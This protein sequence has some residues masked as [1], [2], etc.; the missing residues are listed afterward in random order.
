MLGDDPAFIPE[1]EFLELPFSNLEHME[2]EISQ[3]TTQMSILSPDSRRL[4]LSQG[5][6]MIG[7]NLLPSSSAV[8][9]Y[10]LPGNDLFTTGDSA[11]NLGNYGGIFDDEGLLDD[12]DFEVQHDGQLVEIDA[13]ERERRKGIIVAKQE[14]LGSDSATSGQHLYIHGGG[15]AGSQDQVLIDADGDFVMVMDDDLNILPDAE[16]FPAM[17]DA[18]ALQNQLEIDPDF[19]EHPSSDSAAAPMKVRR[20]RSKK[21][22][23]ADEKISLPNSVLNGWQREYLPN[24]DAAIEAKTN[25][26]GSS[27]AKKNAYILTVGNGIGNAGQ[28]MGSTALPAE[29]SQFFGEGLMLSLKRIL[30]IQKTNGKRKSSSPDLE[31]RRVRG[32]QDSGDNLPRGDADEM[33]PAFDDETGT[34]MAREAISVLEDHHSL[35]MPWNVSARGRSSS[36]QHHLPSS[37]GRPRSLFGAGTGGSRL[38]SASPLFGHG[39][40]IERFS[41]IDIDTEDEQDAVA[42]QLMNESLAQRDFELFGPAAAVGTQTAATSQWL[43]EAMRK[44]SENFLEY[45]KASAMSADDAELDE[46][47]GEENAGRHV[48]FQMLFPPGEHTVLVAAQAFHHVLSLATRGM[49]GVEQDHEELDARIVLTI[50]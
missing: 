21:F 46:L 20:R 49:L 41:D 50:T 28:G 47:G 3:K 10:Q 35:A 4:S 43:G 44:E 16:A 45:V 23:A 2:L 25:R 12:L 31:E 5:G 11:L 17:A 15:H 18:A 34:E 38:T 29:L 9:P 33:L 27:R 40:D 24:M 48:D 22:I 1:L 30:P 42:R 8:S 37:L 26:H 13:T 32:R 14:R 19:S 6:S 36:V 39:K 7:L